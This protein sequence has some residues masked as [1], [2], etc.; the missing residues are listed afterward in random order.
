M[1][2]S[3]LSRES[4]DTLSSRASIR[5]YLAKGQKGQDP[6]PVLEPS[7]RGRKTPMRRNEPT[8]LLLL[9]DPSCDIQG[10]GRGKAQS[11]VSPEETPEA[12]RAPAEPRGSSPDWVLA[13]SAKLHL[14]LKSG[15]SQPVGRCTRRDRQFNAR[16]TCW[17]VCDSR[18]VDGKSA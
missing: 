13:H 3:R 6:A 11:H 4:Q 12:S 10:P 1:S 14:S 7:S 5:R 9:R 16:P 2:H 17:A 15:E 18:A 8:S